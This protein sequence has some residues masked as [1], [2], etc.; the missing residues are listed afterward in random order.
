LKIKF[1]SFSIAFTNA[2]VRCS[3]RAEIV[4]VSDPAQIVHNFYYIFLVV[5]LSLAI[6]NGNHFDLSR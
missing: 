6:P 5:F 1:H 2:S 3:A 4:S